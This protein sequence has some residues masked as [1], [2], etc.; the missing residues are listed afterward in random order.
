[1]KIQIVAD[2]LI[3]FSC[4]FLIIL[5]SNYTYEIYRFESK[6]QNKDL[7]EQKKER[8]HNNF[9]SNSEFVCGIIPKY[10]IGILKS[11]KTTCNNFKWPW[12]VLIEAEKNITLPGFII[13][14]RLILSYCYDEIKNA[15]KI[16]HFE[17][18]LNSYFVKSITCINFFSIIE[19]K[20][21]INFNNFFMPICIQ[22]LDGSIKNLKA[23]SWFLFFKNSLL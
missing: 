15:S 23:F 14:R 6:F 12:D 13:S 16:W 11:L 9:T 8:D 3:L 19:L 7:I 1:M 17:N 2:N 22:H 10:Q 21:S 20:S 5:I 18:K 4:I